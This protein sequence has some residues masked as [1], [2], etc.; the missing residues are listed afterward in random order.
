MD[1]NPTWSISLPSKEAAKNLMEDLFYGE[2][3]GS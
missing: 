3:T 1:D 2:Y